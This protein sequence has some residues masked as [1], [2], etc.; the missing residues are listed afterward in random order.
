MLD[1]VGRISLDIDLTQNLKE[2]I[3]SAADE[4]S[5]G[6][7]EGVEKGFSVNGLMKRFTDNIQNTVKSTMDNVKSTFDNSLKAVSNNITASI[8]VVK[9]QALNA[10]KE[11]AAS[12]KGIKT[13]Q[14]FFDTGNIPIPKNNLGYASAQPRAPNIPKIDTG[15]NME[16]I[17]AQI[18]NLTQSLDIT[19]ATIEQQKEKLAQLKESYNNAF[20]GARKNKIEEE[21]LKTEATINRLTATS[22]KAG[23]KLADLD[24]Q[25]ENLNNAAKDATAGVKVMDENLKNTS[26]SA[27]KAADSI[28]LFGNNA[29]SST[30]KASNGMSMI[31]KMLD[32][33]I[34]RM[35]IF[36][37]I[38][39]GLTALGTFLGEAMMTN[40]QFARSLI[41]V[42]TNLEVAFMPIYQAV[43]P[44]LTSLMNALSKVTAY[45]AS[46]VN[47]LFGKTYQASYGAAKNLNTSI[48]SMKA[49]EEQSKKTS[50]ATEGIGASAKKASKEAKGSLASFDEINQLQLDKDK[51][52]GKNAGNGAGTLPSMIAPGVDLTPAGAAMKNLT[53]I[54]T[55]FKK[56]LETLFAPMKAA[57]KAEGPSVMTEFRN[58]IKG[59]E[60]TIK[61]FFNVLASP[62]V[63]GFLTAVNE[64]V[65]SIVKL[66]LKIYDSFI[67]PIVNWFIDL[68]P[69]AAKGLTPIVNAVK[70]FV[71]YLAGP[72]FGYLQ[73]FLSAVLGAV[74]GI[75]TFKIIL[76]VV[77]WF[78]KLKAGISGVWA[79]ILANPIAAIIA[80]VAA[81]VVAL[82]TLYNTN[83]SFR[84]KVNAIWTAI[85]TFFV[86]LWNGIKDTA[87]SVWTAISDFFTALWTGISD[88]ASTIFNGIKEFFITLWDGIKF[89]TETVWNGIKEFFITL[90]N[91]ISS[92]ANE[93][94]SGVSNVITSVWNGVSATSTSI[95][96]AIKLF[97]STLWNGLKTTATT[98]WNAIS[99]VFTNAWSSIKNVT[100]TTWNGIKTFLGTLWNGLKDTAGIVIEGLQKIFGG[101]ID[102]I[103]GV[104]TTNW[105][106]AWQ[107]VKQIFKNVFDSLYGIVKVPLNL[108]IHA[109]NWVIEGLNHIHFNLPK[110]DILGEYAGKSFGINIS[111]IPALA[112]GGIIDQPTLAM[113]GE[114][115]K[116]AVVPL[117]NT[118]FADALAG[119]VGTAVLQAMQFTDNNKSTKDDRDIVIEL[120]GTIFSRLL[121]PY[122]DKENQRI[123]NRVIVKMT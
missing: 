73:V 90:W 92:E 121:K 79:L 63:Q 122:L 3:N 94:F 67:L 11:I 110:W 93:I 47:A 27:K 22:D 34:I 99:K 81:A 33:M 36:N 78:K 55:G 66:A 89:I 114:R 95:W 118:E 112:R 44:A 48:A 108:I 38:I 104:F 4:I 109:I 80:L 9:E 65:L 75:G 26:N 52:K 56:V 32:R 111:P 29:K 62:P 57:W 35:F 25:F 18:D 31:G 46:F 24:K 113:V 10:V 123:G 87:I 19:N 59:T 21:I 45:I 102:F 120:D 96:N 106:L 5:S 43:L 54:A 39:K 64:L 28:N 40:T 72:G 16:V 12:L 53:N 17:K 101:L 83:E 119:A 23:F 30:S 107:G 69:P 20:N 37:T 71:D 77:E 97:L 41:Q 6:L 14:N 1:S 98:V 51:D 74:A 100:T 116:E 8:N 42:K 70:K 58:A 88:T 50:K 115:G 91:G 105:G 85:S 60:N 61:H 103:T 76:S 86:N 82:V 84:N 49:M 68:L 13:P 7:Q 15:I 2:Q 117:E